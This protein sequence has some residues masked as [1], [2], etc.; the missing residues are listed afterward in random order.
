M[1]LSHG[2][3]R[4]NVEQG[5]WMESTETHFWPSGNSEF[6]KGDADDEVANQLTGI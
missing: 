6:W 5:N 2:N 3:Y 1:T 4:I